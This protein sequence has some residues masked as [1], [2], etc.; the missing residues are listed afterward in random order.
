MEL[1]SR[2]VLIGVDCGEVVNWH[3]VL[4]LFKESVG[5]WQQEAIVSG[6]RD[7]LR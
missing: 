1:E 3:Q 2:S 5:E 4:T 6:V 7:I